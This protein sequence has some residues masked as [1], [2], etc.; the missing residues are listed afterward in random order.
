[1]KTPKEKAKLLFSEF[2]GLA[3]DCTC[4]E[5]MCI[6]SHIGHKLAKKVS[7]ICIEKQK[8]QLRRI[9]TKSAQFEYDELFKIQGEL[10][11]L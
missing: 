7:L 10:I 6:C 9:G 4:I 1:M 5:Y 2:K 11:K 3:D 8:E